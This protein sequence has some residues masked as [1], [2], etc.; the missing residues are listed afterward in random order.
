MMRTQHMPILYCSLTI[1]CLLLVRVAILWRLKCAW[2]QIMGIFSTQTIGHAMDIEEQDE[3]RDSGER[4]VRAQR[5]SANKK[6]LILLLE[7][8]VRECIRI[9]S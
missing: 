3:N 1:L 8:I 2:C 6:C 9:E 5:A 4:G 7:A